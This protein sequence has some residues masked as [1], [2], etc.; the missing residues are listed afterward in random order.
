MS[1]ILTILM[2]LYLRRENARRD[3]WA[4]ENNKL[5]ENYTEDEDLDTDSPESPT[6]AYVRQRKFVPGQKIITYE[7]FEHDFW[8]RSHHGQGKGLGEQCGHRM[9]LQLC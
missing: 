3:K 2:S 6:Q 9:W 4:V 5:P 8:K 7:M 1:A